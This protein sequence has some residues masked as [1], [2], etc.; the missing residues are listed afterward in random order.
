MYRVLEYFTDLQDNNYPYNVGDTY[1]HEG[2]EPTEERINELSGTG[3]VRHRPLIE[4]IEEAV[5]TAEEADKAEPE[6][7]P[8]KPKR[9]KRRKDDE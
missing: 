5:N 4:A 1:P 8:E 9:N 7:E 6:T 2:Y 3:N